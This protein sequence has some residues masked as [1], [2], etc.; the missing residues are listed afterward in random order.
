LVVLAGFMRLVGPEFLAK[1]GG[2][3]IN[4]H[5][6][7]LPSFP[8]IHGPRDALAA[9]VKLTGATLIVVDDGIDTGPILAQV[10]V[11]VEA[12]DDVASL[13]ERIKVAERAMLIE[14]VGR[15]ARE[16]VAT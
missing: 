7:L 14:W 5:P 6:A 4:S 11:P 10:A 2:R 8:G 15:L 9:G 1:F 13:H 3:T 12:D 16:G